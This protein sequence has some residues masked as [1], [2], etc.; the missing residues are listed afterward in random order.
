MQ[1]ILPQQ[2]GLEVSSV[3]YRYSTV[4][5][6]EDD[7]VVYVQNED[8]A[9]TG[10]I[11]REKDDWSGKPSNTINKIVP[12][13]NVLIDRWGDGSI[14]V[15]GT[16]AV[17][18]ARVVYNYKFDPCF[19]P[20]TSPSCV[21]YV[22]PMPDIYEV[23]LSFLD[24]ESA[25]VDSSTS[26]EYDELEDEEQNEID[27]KK[28]IRNKVRK[29]RQLRL[30]L[31]LS[32]NGN[33]LSMDSNA[34]QTHAELMAL[35]IIPTSYTGSIDGGHYN[36]TITLDDGKLPSSKKAKRVGLAQQLLHNQLVELQYDNP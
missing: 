27:R 31:A 20:Q 35:S 36:E 1:N 4:K 34:E 33:A 29:V 24:A 7:M 16:G 6:T 25:L 5:K 17:E 2:L 14:V 9:G 32:V 8:A 26:N 10:Y 28:S 21:G 15:E 18:N 19:D 23:D 30:E 11:F 22:Q 12:V 3:V 13:P